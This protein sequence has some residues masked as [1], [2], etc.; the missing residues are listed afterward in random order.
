MDNNE[1]YY[2]KDDLEERHLQF[3]TW[4]HTRYTWTAN[5]LPLPSVSSLASQPLYQ[6]NVL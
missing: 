1:I 3:N 4:E 2:N 5:N 6:R